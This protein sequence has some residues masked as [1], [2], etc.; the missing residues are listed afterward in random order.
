M[1]K[2]LKAKANAVQTRKLAPNLLQK[3]TNQ[4]RMPWYVQSTTY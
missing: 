3:W 2:A 4:D 1:G